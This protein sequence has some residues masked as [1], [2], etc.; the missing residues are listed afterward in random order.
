MACRSQYTARGFA[1]Q[2][3]RVHLD[4]KAP[5][6]APL[7]PGAPLDRVAELAV[8][9]EFA[10]RLGDVLRRRSTLW[11]EPDRGRVA[12]TTVGA[13]M[14]RRLGWSPARARAEFQDYD[15]LLWQEETLIQ[16]THETS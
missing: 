4:P 12:A 15:A 8:E 6:P 16:R 2:A 10:R 11:L 13:T 1:V 9:H 5:L 14:A 7:A 3:T